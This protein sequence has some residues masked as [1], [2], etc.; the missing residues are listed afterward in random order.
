MALCEESTKD[1]GTAANLTKVSAGVRDQI[2]D[3]S[4]LWYATDRAGRAS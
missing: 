3:L 4:L 2:S 1:A